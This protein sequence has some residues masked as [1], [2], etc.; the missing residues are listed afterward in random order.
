MTYPVTDRPLDVAIIGAGIAGLTAAYHLSRQQPD[1]HFH[2]FEAAPRPGGWLH[3]HH[4]DGYHLEQGPNT[5]LLNAPELIALVNDLNLQ[6]VP[7]ARAARKRYIYIGGRLIT[8]Q[9]ALLNAL[10]PAGV[11]GFL[12]QQL[13]GGPLP[14]PNTET[15][16]DFTRRLIGP[17]VLDHLVAPL[18]SGIYAGD[19]EQLGYEDVFAP[20]AAW[21]RQ[22]HGSLVRGLLQGRRHRAKARSTKSHRYGIA[23][24]QGGLGVL[25]KTLAGRLTDHLSYNTPITHLTWDPQAQVFTGYDANH[26]PCFHAAGVVLAVPMPV[27]FR[28][29]SGLTPELGDAPSLNDLRATPSASVRVVHLGLPKA[30]LRWQPDGFGALI[31]RGQGIATLGSLW[32]SAMFPDRAPSGHVLLSNFLGGSLH[33]EAMAWSDDQCV[34]TV[35]EDLARLGILPTPTL[36]AMAMVR[37]LTCAEAIPQYLVGHR[38][39]VEALRATLATLFQDRLLLTGN[40]TDGVSVGNTVSSALQAAQACSWPSVEASMLFLDPLPLS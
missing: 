17:G 24:L 16:A 33:P 27:A 34:Q 30:A 5:L 9:R 12:R 3:T 31:P 20:V 4:V 15:V 32:P 10:T 8:A 25:P 28:L 29:L 2:V 1:K 37:V 23:S 11:L 18:C 36:P 13:Q 26:Q 6:V 14:T 35:C 40:W 21:E 39:R 7:A 38:R 22:G 19:P